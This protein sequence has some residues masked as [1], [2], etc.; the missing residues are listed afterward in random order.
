MFVVSVGERSPSHPAFAVKGIIVTSNFTVFRV[1]CVL[2]FSVLPGHALAASW[3]PVAV[4]S[5]M[6]IFVDKDSLKKKGA[7]VNFWQWQL[8]GRAIGKTDSAKSH[9]VMDCTTQQ[10]K[11]VYMIAIAELD[12]VQ[13][14]GKVESKFDAIQPN[15]LESSVLDAVCNNKFTGKS[16]GT[17][18]IYDVRS[19]MYQNLK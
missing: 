9:V 19:F 4:N 14:E 3:Y 6:M 18:S 12:T 1:L 13:Q 7:T 15:S 8:F 11:T 5:S 10:R 17:V 16:Q 2:G